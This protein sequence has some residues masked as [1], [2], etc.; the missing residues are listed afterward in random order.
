MLKGVLK[1]Y[2]ATIVAIFIAAV[3]AGIT[4][5]YNTVLG[6]VELVIVFVLL[7]YGYLRIFRN[8]RRLSQQVSALN[9]SMRLDE[10]ERKQFESYPFAVVLCDR[11]GNV[12]WYNHKY[13]ELVIEKCDFDQPDIMDCLDVSN[14]FETENLPYS[15][16]A[17]IKG[18]Y[19]TVMPVRHD[20]ELMALYFVEDTQLKCFRMAYMKTRP[21]ALMINI[22]SLEHTEDTY[23]H[24][25]FSTIYA[26]INKIISSWLDANHCVFR[27]Y[28]D[29]RY[30]ALTE[31]DNFSK[32]TAKRFDLLDLVRNYRYDGQDSGITLSVGIGMEPTVREC[33]NSAR[34]ALDMAR[35]RGG[36][37]VA[38]KKD[39]NFEFFGG[40]G[41]KKDKRGKIKSRTVA[42]ALCEIIEKSDH[43]LLMGHSFSD[44]DAIGSCIGLTAICESV[45]VKANIVVNFETTLAM[46]LIELCEQNG[47]KGLFVNTEAG[48][49][50]I[51]DNTLLIVSDIMRPNN[52]ESRELLDVVK[53]VVVIDHHRMAVDKIADPVLLFHEPYASSSS[54]MV[55]ELIQYAPSK[56]K[57]LPIQAESLMAGIILDTKNFS[58]RV[59]VRTFEAAAFLREKKT[60]TVRVKK[61]F[62][63][64]EEE[65]SI[66]N[67]ILLSAKICDNYAVAFAENKDSDIRKLSS[68]AADEMLDIKGVEASFVVYPQGSGMAVSARSL[69][70]IN[71]QLIMEKLGGGGHQSMAGAQLKDTT[72]Q[73]AM[74]QLSQAI[75]Y[76]FNS[77]V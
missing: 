29:E 70:T 75:Q 33:E 27:R 73:Q 21:V 7:V 26:E 28:S 77:E 15:V 16:D 17:D 54:E 34:Q 49:S 71:V 58:F 5:H 43:V 13:N 18:T 45:G 35:G 9:A 65:K 10:N 64:T 14:L 62:A 25:D 11:S 52:V 50:L 60:D 31:Y 46:P 4:L 61:L 66:V 67:K 57:L 40:I 1:S 39:D 74:E 6:A 20:E 63:L 3:S 8:F 41:A 68:C 47:M 30:F 56:P 69:G 59:G 22:D 37:Q 12:V 53:S 36:D 51:T 24:I 2:S 19:F 42:A 76:Y 23:S 32:M 55:V 48:M 72:A 44:F 38:I